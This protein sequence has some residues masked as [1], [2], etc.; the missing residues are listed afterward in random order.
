M[1]LSASDSI[2]EANV[3]ERE[4]TVDEKP[5]LTTDLTDLNLETEMNLRPPPPSLHPE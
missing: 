1:M 4:I 3:S 2:E 5:Q